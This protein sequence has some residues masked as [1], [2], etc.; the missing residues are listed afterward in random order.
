MGSKYNRQIRKIMNG[1]Y[2]NAY[3]QVKT[4][5]ETKARDAKFFQRLIIAI[6]YV[7]K[8]DFNAFL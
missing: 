5:I 1:N 4:Y 8:K 6:R 7:F 2:R 3:E